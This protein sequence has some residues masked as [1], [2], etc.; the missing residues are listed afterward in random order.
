MQGGS[1]VDCDEKESV[2]ICTRNSTAKRGLTARREISAPNFGKKDYIFPDSAVLTKY[3]ALDIYFLLFC[4]FSLNCN[5][6]CLPA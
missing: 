4:F 3:A 5:G 1:F 6:I 2:L